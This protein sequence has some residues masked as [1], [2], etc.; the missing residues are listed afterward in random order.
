VIARTVSRREHLSG[1]LYLDALVALVV[2]QEA[3]QALF[4]D[5]RVELLRPPV[6]RFLEAEHEG[7]AQHVVDLGLVD[8][9]VDGQLPHLL[10][11]FPRQSGHRGK[12]QHFLV[13]LDGRALGS[14][15]ERLGARRNHRRHDRRRPVGGHEC[16]RV[17]GSGRVAA[18]VAA[19]GAGHGQHGAEREQP[20]AR[21]AGG[22]DMRG[23]G[24]GARA[25]RGSKRSEHLCR[26]YLPRSL[27]KSPRSRAACPA[28]DV[29]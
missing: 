3:P 14:L 5:G 6:E 27:A 11:T 10:L 20:R 1:Q 19:T 23:T 4:E 24:A 12:E 25:V 29:Q 15:V 18:P 21:G 13:A 8:P 2:E 9:A 22:R 7:I 28:R 17:A 16:A 26:I